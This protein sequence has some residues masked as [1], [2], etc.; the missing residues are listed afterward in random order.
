M[1]WRARRALTIA[2][3]LMAVTAA[4]PMTA[5]T[6]A[7]EHPG[8]CKENG[9]AVAANAQAPG[10]FGAIVRENA[11]INDEVVLFKTLLCAP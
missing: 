1:L 5:P 8:G 3:G 4:T 9:Q 11:P 7:Q 2:A 6:R 10:P